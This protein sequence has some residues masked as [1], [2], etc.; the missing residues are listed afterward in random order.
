MQ[1]TFIIFLCIIFFSQI[2]PWPVFGGKNFFADD[3]NGK[4]ITKSAMKT[5]DELL[6]RIKRFVSTINNPSDNFK[7]GKTN[8]TIKTF[9]DD[10]VMENSGLFDGDIRLSK[11]QAE[12]LIDTVAEVAE[13]L[14]ANVSDIVGDS[15]TRK[16]RKIDT[17]FDYEWEL[18]IPYIINAGV[19]K[20]LVREALKKLESETCLRFQ[21][22]KVFPRGQAGLKYFPGDGCYSN[23]GR[24][25][26]N[27]LQEISIGPGC[28]FIPTIQH[29]TM[30]ALGFTHEQ[31]RADRDKYLQILIN[32]V[33]DF[34]IENFLKLQLTDA[35]DYGLPYDYGSAMHYNSYSSSKNG[36]PTMLPYNPLYQMTMG[37]K[38]EATF[39][40]IMVLNLYNCEDICLNKIS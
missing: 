18:T 35:L 20:N 40:N 4:S 10:D 13:E 21:E 25:S 1:K 22:H 30:H 24:Q 28:N 32:N 39:L 26:L 29:E 8:T 15:K 3:Q 12:Y 27:E 23:V 14:G 36:E 31:S 5:L 7:E 2:Q 9:R 34:A 11:K 6:R 19:D 38:S 33:K 37:S 17:R 16:K